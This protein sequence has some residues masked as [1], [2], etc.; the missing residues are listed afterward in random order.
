MSTKGSL[1]LKRRVERF[2]NAVDAALCDAA[3]FNDNCPDRL[4][5]AI[6]YSLLGSGKRLRPL[7][8]LFANGLCGG[9]CFNAIPAACAVEMIHAYSLVHDDLPAMDND[10]L[11]RGRLTCHKKFDEPTAILVGDALIPLAFEMLG[12]LPSKELLGIC[13]LE[14]ARA[15]GAAALV[16]GQMDDIANEKNLDR[17]HKNASINLLEQIHLRKTGALIRVSLRLGGLIAG[18]SVAQIDAL[19]RYGKNFG[20]AFQITDDLLDV[21][22]N[23]NAA[24]KRL[25]KDAEMNKWTYPALLGIKKSEEEAQRYVNEAI[26]ALKIFDNK[27]PDKDILIKTAHDLI[28][29]NK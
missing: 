12:K 7:F 22:G 25:H 9:D 29:R 6:R 26:Y 14:L 20:L 13:S 23:E 17:K 15:A 8:V 24:G 21:L 10:D 19:D 5:D 4:G 2:R 1:F 27:L 28:G 16:G 18:G 11:R 3:K